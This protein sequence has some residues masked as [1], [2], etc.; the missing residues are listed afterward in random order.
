[1]VSVLEI[2]FK[3]SFKNI[4]SI[5]EL[6]VTIYYIHTLVLLTSHDTEN[7]INITEFHTIIE[8]L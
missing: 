5:Q 7:D 4:S 6:L 1:M 3:Y 2:M 8:T